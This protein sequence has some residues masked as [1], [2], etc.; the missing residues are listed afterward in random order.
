MQQ[1]ESGERIEGRRLD[2]DKADELS[3]LPYRQFLEA[4]YSTSESD[5]TMQAAALYKVV[6]QH[7]ELQRLQHLLA[8]LKERYE[9]N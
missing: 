7:Y 2:L 4:Y 8:E 1:P 3:K 6:D 9:S 5:P